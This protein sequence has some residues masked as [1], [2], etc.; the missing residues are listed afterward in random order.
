MARKLSPE[1]ATVFDDTESLPEAS[2]IEVF[3]RKLAET[4]DDSWELTLIPGPWFSHLPP[5][6]SSS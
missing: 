6:P 5:E 4:K 2:D 1:E 3:V